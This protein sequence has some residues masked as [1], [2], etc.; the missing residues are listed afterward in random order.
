[1]DAVSL[2]DRLLDFSARVGQVVDALPKKR[3]ANHI[4]S[5]LSGVLPL[6]ARTTKKGAVQKAARISSTSYASP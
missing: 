5:Q 6:R 3:L 4:A 1:M 2:A